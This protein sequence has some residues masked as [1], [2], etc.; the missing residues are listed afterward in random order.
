MLARWRNHFFQLL[1]VRGVSYIRQTEIQT[2]EPLL[3]EPCACEIEMAIEKLRRHKSP[4]INQIPLE[5]LKQVVEQFA[6]EIHNLLILFGIRRNC[7]RSGRSHSLYLSV[8]RVTKQIIVI[9]ES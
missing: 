8:R 7:L 2:A 9:T 3:P 1:S 4:V 5:L 6:L